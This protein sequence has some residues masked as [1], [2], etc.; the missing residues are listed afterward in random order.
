MKSS[1]TRS[2][3][4]VVV[5]LAVQPAT[6][7]K[8]AGA[9]RVAIRCSQACR[10]IQVA[11]DDRSDAICLAIFGESE[12]KYMACRVSSKTQCV[13]LEHECRQLCVSS[14]DDRKLEP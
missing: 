7:P 10:E 5:L 12:E 14:R 3:A 2:I 1:K 8:A 13:Y 11:C 6:H 4:L 9:G